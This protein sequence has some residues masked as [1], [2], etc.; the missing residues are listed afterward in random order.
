MGK[1]K[2]AK[3]KNLLRSGLSV[4]IIGAIVILLVLFGVISSAI[5][6]VS[7]TNAFKREYSTT[8]YHMADTAATLVKGDHLSEYVDG[9]YAYEYQQTRAYLDAYCKKIRVSLIYVIQVDRSDYGRFVSVFNLVDNTVDDTEY[10][11]WEPGYKRDTTNDEYR[12]KYKAI[13][14]QSSEYETVYRIKTTDGQHPHITTMVPVKD[15][16]DEV[17]AIL[18]IQR[19]VRELYDARRPYLINI[20][21]STVLLAVAVSVFA[22]FFIRKQFVLPVQQVS[23]EATRFARENTQGEPL[24]NISRF[25]VISNLAHSIDTL[26]RDMCSYVDNLTAVTAEKERIGAELSL[27]ST[28]QDNSVPNVFPAFPGRDDF[29]IY[30]SMTPA[31]EVGGDFYNFF[32]IDDDHLA[33]V[34]GDVS[35]KG[36]PAALFMMVTNILITDRTKMGGTPEQILDYVNENICAHNKADMFV[37]V[38]LGILQLSTGKLTAANAGHEYPVLRTGGGAYELVRDKHGFVVGGMETTRYKG[39]EM[40]LQ[41]GSS[42]FLYTDGVPEASDKENRLFGVGRMLEVLNADPG[43]SPEKVLSGMSAAIEEYA[44]GAEQFDDITMLCIEYKG[45]S[46]G[47]ENA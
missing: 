23:D 21:I 1:D 30:A 15:S 34:I 22:G 37:T 28:I 13:Y 26:E 7:F 39:Y 18:C 45:S 44:G 43:A 32:L 46:E 31:R 17:C 11:A 12:Q 4:N 38:W 41:P 33:I 36:I 3:K 6:L 2:T 19:P 14:E 29:D 27:A 40:T 35:G 10:T 9:A 42:L 20:A 24:G 25:E 5:G 47:K 16:S 8:T